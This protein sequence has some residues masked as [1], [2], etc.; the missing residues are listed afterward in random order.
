MDMRKLR[1]ILFEGPQAIRVIVMAM[2]MLLV[3]AAPAAAAGLFFWDGTDP[4]AWSDA[5]EWNS[6][7]CSHTVCYPQAS[8]DDAVIEYDSGILDI[9]LSENL[10]IDDLSID[11]L[12]QFIGLKFTTSGPTTYTLTADSVTLLGSVTMTNLAGVVAEGE[13]ECEE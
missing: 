11:V 3:A 5:G 7:G 1:Q 9:T 4:S 6:I 8:D 12:G 2:A 13:D 10:T